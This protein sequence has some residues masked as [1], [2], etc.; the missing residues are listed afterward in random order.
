M[1]NTV[2]TYGIVQKKE[3]VS[4]IISMISPTETPFT[5]LT[6]KDTVH[7]WDF[8][9]MEDVLRSSAANA[10]VEGVTATPSARTQPTLKE[11]VTQIFQ[12]TYEVTGTTDAIS[13]YGRAKESARLAKNAAKALKLDLERAFVGSQQTMVKPVDNTTARVFAGVQ[14]QINTANRLPT[15]GVGTAPTEANLL[16]VLNTVFKAGGT[17]SVLMVT[18]DDSTLVADFA[19][20]SGRAR[21]INNGKN[22]RQ[23][24]NVV[25]LYVSPYGEQKVVLNRELKSSDMLILDPAMWVK[26]VLKGRD[27]F[28]QKMGITGDKEM[29]QIVGEF[30]LKNKNSKGSGFITRSVS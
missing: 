13:I 10:N 14:A 6:S 26:I 23:I 24:V 12:D 29:T 19:K 27:W 15:G 21:Q 4:D 1:P 7:N 30:S 25:E 16:S 9:W 3:D 11:N 22:D 8:N 18:P 17:P 5:S 20:A 2:D 28:S